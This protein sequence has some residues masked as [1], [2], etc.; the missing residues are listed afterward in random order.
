MNAPFSEVFDFPSSRYVYILQAS[1]NLQ[2]IITG[3]HFLLFLLLYQLQLKRH[4]LYVILKFL[5]MSLEKHNLKMCSNG[6]FYTLYIRYQKYSQNI[7]DIENLS[8]K[9][10]RVKHWTNW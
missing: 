6:L 8:N 10:Q 4:L 5:L 1:Q 9:L 7:D 3:N 2:G